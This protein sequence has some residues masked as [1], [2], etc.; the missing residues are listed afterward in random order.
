MTLGP[1]HFDP[2][3][4]TTHRE[5]SPDVALPVVVAQEPDHAGD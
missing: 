4:N 5:E 1:F 2:Y 3:L